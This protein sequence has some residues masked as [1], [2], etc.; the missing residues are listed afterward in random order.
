MDKKKYIVK[1]KFKCRLLGTILLTKCKHSISSFDT[2][3]N[4]ISLCAITF[5]SN[6]YDKK[7][8]MSFINRITILRQLTIKFGD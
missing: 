3:H 6:D 5:N 4:K 1:V 8:N 7:F 2:H